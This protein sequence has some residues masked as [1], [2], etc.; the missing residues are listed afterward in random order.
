MSEVHCGQSPRLVPAEPE[1]RDE[2]TQRALAPWGGDKAA[3]VFTTLVQHT[4]LFESWS[5]FARKLLWE[6]ELS[7]RHREMVILRIAWRTGSDYEWGQ[8]V[9]IA[10]R[11]EMSDREIELVAADPAAFA[12]AT[13]R[14]LMVATDE[15]FDNDEIG[16]DTWRTLESLLTTEQLIEM[17]FLAGGYRMLAGA[18][19]T[20]KV[21]LDRPM[22]PL[23]ASRLQPI[24]AEEGIHEQRV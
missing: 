14:Y 10:R 22:P 5:P 18:L 13:D 23:G 3:N 8:H 21:Q 24:G 6:S 15:L 9:R 12:D 16:D 2:R 11:A 17:V 1:D 4:D 20:L 7:D 19:K